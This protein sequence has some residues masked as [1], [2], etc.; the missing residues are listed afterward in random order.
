M[1]LHLVQR[2]R[3]GTHGG[4][5]RGKGMFINLQTR[6]LSR[7]RGKS[8]AAKERNNRSR[9]LRATRPRVC[10]GGRGKFP[11][12][13]AC[14]GEVGQ[15]PLQ[16]CVWG[17]AGAGTVAA[18]STAARRVSTQRLRA[19]H[20]AFSTPCLRSMIPPCDNMRFRE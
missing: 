8:S 12:S 3:L 16:S 14:G 11:C 7:Q 15:V 5:Q 2:A 6:P 19:N 10:V 1:V 13:R 4:L 20:V 17:G 18:N 9:A